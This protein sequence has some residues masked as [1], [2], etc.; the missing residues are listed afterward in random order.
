MPKLDSECCDSKPFNTGN[1]EWKVKLYPKG[2]GA[3][4]GSYLLLY[5][6]LA[7]PTALPPGSKVYAQTVLRIIDQKQAKHYFGKGNYWF[8]ASNNENGASRF[9][10]IS[11]FTSQNMGYLVKD[12]CLVEAE[13]TVL[14]VVDA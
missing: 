7:N 5:L 6:A 12:I 8:S 10:S 4:L 9:I 1:Y 13:V 14:G 3:E 11:N 2:K